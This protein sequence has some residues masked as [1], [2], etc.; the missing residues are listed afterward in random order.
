[1]GH[2]PK[3]RNCIII[4]SQ[5]PAVERIKVWNLDAID[6]LKRVFRQ[7]GISRNNSLV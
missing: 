7:D 1:M 2:N 5:E 6:F 4:G 3:K